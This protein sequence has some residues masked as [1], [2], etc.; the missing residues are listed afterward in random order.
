MAC[1]PCFNCLRNFR[2][3]QE[4]A[5]SLPI[6]CHKCRACYSRSCTDYSNTEC[7][8]GDC[9]ECQYCLYLKYRPCGTCI[10]CLSCRACE[11]CTECRDC[12][13]C[14]RCSNPRFDA[15]CFNNWDTSDNGWW[16]IARKFILNSIFDSIDKVTVHT[17]DPSNLLSI[18]CNCD[19]F[20]R[21]FAPKDLCDFARKA[22][23]YRNELY[24]HIPELKITPALIDHIKAKN[25]EE[26]IK[27]LNKLS[28]II[29]GHSA[30]VNLRL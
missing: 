4:L 15:K 9:R 7:D 1:K 19:L 10:P 5:T 29:T 27:D 12:K 11:K 25:F 30:S 17:I 16:I 14:F 13:R 22:R 2:V 3:Q 21:K 28:T 26:I 24:G 23:F 18:I 6:K 8:L 20:S